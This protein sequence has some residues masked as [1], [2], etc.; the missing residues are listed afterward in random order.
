MSAIVLDTDK[1]TLLDQSGSGR[2]PNQV[3]TKE[4]IPVYTVTIKKNEDGIGYWAKSEMDNG[5]CFTDGDTIKETQESMYE[6]V[7]LYL[8]DDYPDVTDFALSFVM[9]K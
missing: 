6:S 4:A 1:N 9:A 2:T 3:L 7:A 5:C 8:E